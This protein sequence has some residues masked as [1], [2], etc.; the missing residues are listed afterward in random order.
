MINRK[1]P[2][3]GV[4]AENTWPPYAGYVKRFCNR[5]GGF[6]PCSSPNEALRQVAFDERRK[7]HDLLLEGVELDMKANWQRKER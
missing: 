6:T 5:I 1:P 2:Q 4:K 7:I 3:L